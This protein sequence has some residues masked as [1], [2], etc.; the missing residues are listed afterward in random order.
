MNWGK[1]HSVTVI[2]VLVA[3]LGAAGLL[4]S[5]LPKGTPSSTPS[6]SPPGNSPQC[7]GTATCFTGSV[8]YIVDGDTL[9]VGSTRIRLAL[10]NS[11]EAGQPGYAE[12]KQ[13][14][15]Q[16]CAVGSPA[17]VDEGHGQAGGSYGRM[18]AGMCCGGGVPNPAVTL[19]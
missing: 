11:P 4:Y 19:L 9:D 3:V 12:A 5:Y 2:V 6:G 14:T 7:K 1:R 15:A 13:F 16:T 18:S 8:T 10:V 17:L